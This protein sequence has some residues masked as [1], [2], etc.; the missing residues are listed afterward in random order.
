MPR[1]SLPRSLAIPSAA[2]TWLEAAIYMA[3]APK[4]NAAYLA[5]DAALKEVREGPLRSVPPHLRDRHRPG[6]DELRHL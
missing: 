3:L 1:L 5:I 2:L 6:S 4:S